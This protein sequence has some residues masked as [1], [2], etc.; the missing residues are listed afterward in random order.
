MRASVALEVLSSRF[1]VVVVHAELW[2][3]RAGIFDEDWVR[4]RCVAYF[5]VRPD[6]LQHIRT[7]VEEFLA[8]EPPGAV[9]DTVYAFR[10]SVAPMAMRCFDAGGARARVT[11]LDLDDDEC[12]TKEQFAVL[13]EAAGDAVRAARIRTGLPQMNRFRSVLMPRFDHVFVAGSGDRDVLAARHPGIRI[14]H[15]P[16]AVREPA[17]PRPDTVPHPGR[18]LFVGSLDY[19][20]NEDAV[21]F[22]ARE[23]LPGLRRLDGRLTLRVA[24]VGHSP[25]LVP[26]AA[27]PG[28]DF[29][30]AVAELAAEY[31]A[32]DAVV[33]PLR[34]GGGTRIKILEA[35]AHRAP[36]VST[37][38][39][40]EGLGVVDGEHLLLAAPDAFADACLR[41]SSDPA[42][43]RRLTTNA[44]GLVARHHSV[45]TVRGILAGCLGCG[46]DRPRGAAEPG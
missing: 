25:A 35:F 45:D 36:V 24:G 6:R 40:A 19:L 20:P 15:L 16:N 31:A 7:L 14:H 30:G 43:R 38:K 8:G 39:G 9:L 12:G 1:R 33:V 32:A 28:V 23:I 11:L 2:A 18:M 17:G 3:G 44:H 41:I 29:V 26:V 46:I 42:L 5:R 21:A 34:V 4:A 10:Q 37:P 27:L 22:F 13:H